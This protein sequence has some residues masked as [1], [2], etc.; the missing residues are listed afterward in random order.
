M[1]LVNG[2][3][4]V[5]LAHHLNPAGPE[6]ERRCLLSGVAVVVLEDMGICLQEEPS[7][8]VS[9]PLADH[10]GAQASLQRAGR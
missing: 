8:R 10:L 2:F 1:P 6:Q 9:D 4:N 5:S 3:V 7:I